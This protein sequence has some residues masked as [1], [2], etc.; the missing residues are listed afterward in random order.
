MEALYGCTWRSCRVTLH[1][2]EAVQQAVGTCEHVHS[3][4]LADLPES[5]KTLAKRALRSKPEGRGLQKYM[6]L[7][8][9]TGHPQQKSGSSNPQT[10]MI[11]GNHV[12]ILS[13]PQHTQKHDKVNFR[14]LL[15]DQPHPVDVERLRTNMLGNTRVIFARLRK[16]LTC[17]Q[18]SS[19]KEPTVR[20]C[21]RCVTLRKTHPQETSRHA[22]LQ[23]MKYFAERILAF[24]FD[25]SCDMF[26]KKRIKN[27]AEDPPRGTCFRG[28][29][30]GNLSKGSVHQDFVG[31]LPWGKVKAVEGTG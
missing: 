18:S 27:S 14:C 23:L 17:K 16:S 8:R 28:G 4:A 6:L 12:A 29:H 9:L 13:W 30:H 11:H 7:P 1:V 19:A 10:I 31:L 3:G 21:V 22:D 15:P 24:W 26:S 2:M 25:W 5:H 20:R